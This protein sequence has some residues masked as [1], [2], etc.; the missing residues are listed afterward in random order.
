[1]YSFLHISDLHRSSAQ[2][3]SNIELIAS[4]IADREYY[5]H[6]NT[7][8]PYPQA[9]IVS[10]DIIQGLPIGSSD[11]PTA[12]VEQYQEAYDFLTRLTDEFLM[13]DRS[14]LIMVPGN[15]DVDWN[16]AFSAM[17]LVDS[18]PEN[19]LEL[20]SISKSPYRW[21]W[22]NRS[23]FRIKD[24]TRYAQRFRYFE[25]LY[26]QF[27]QEAHLDI[28]VEP[29]RAWN[30]FALNDGKLLVCGFNS[31]ATNDCFNSVG[32]ILPEVIS[33]SY[34]TMRR[35]TRKR[36][37]NIAVWH[38]DTQGPPE[39]S[40]Y[41]DFDT[42]ALLLGEGYRLGM[43]GH[44]HRSET[45]PYNL[46]MSENETMATVCTGSLCAGRLQLPDGIKRGYSIVAVDTERC[47][48]RVHVR[49]M[50]SYGVFAPARLQKTGG[51]TY[52]DV[53]W[54]E[55]NQSVLVNTGIEGGI[56]VAIVDSI[57]AAMGARDYEAAFINT[58]KEIS[59]LRKNARPLLLEVLTCAQK[60]AEL[61]KEIG[62]PRNPDELL[63]FFLA[64]VTT[65]NWEA[66]REGIKK[67]LE[68]NIIAPPL[69]EDLFSRLKAERGSVQ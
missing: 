25:S 42:L 58:M 66:A 34:L 16:M 45:L 4:L 57:E 10:G 50:I 54:S 47:T 55:G 22:V 11:Y 62:H 59:F 24:A 61:I 7:P 32:S 67:A 28:A 65:R 26:E 64:C 23:L 27:Y 37:L 29:Q 12:L 2:P 36:N 40:D 56:A 46:Y 39:R 8:V 63:K 13:G 52:F 1:M 18:P 60:W 19:I 15:H 31:C 3:I 48:A 41:M 51:Q 38:H 30:L 53:H 17:E 49:E 14:R 6:E 44:Q 43:H 9:I 33:E 35:Y 20:L 21:S 5:V 68:D 69:A